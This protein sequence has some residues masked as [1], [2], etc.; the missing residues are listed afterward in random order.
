MVYNSR[1]QFVL[2]TDVLH[3]YWRF[4]PKLASGWPSGQARKLPPSRHRSLL[5]VLTGELD[6]RSLWV[7]VVT[8]G[9][10][11]DKVESTVVLS[12]LLMAVTKTLV[13]SW[14]LSTWQRL[15]RGFQILFEAF[16]QQTPVDLG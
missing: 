13:T 4:Y 11:D 10:T 12:P 2:E 8:V 7:S 15:C 16:S 14:L 3:Y 6:L 5:E 9:E 1:P